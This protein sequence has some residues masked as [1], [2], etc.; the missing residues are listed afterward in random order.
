MRCGL[1]KY[2]SRLALRDIAK[3]KL[4]SDSQRIKRKEDIMAILSFLVTAILFAY[5]ALPKIQI[6]NQGDMFIWGLLFVIVWLI[7]HIFL[8]LFFGPKPPPPTPEQRARAKA[9]FKIWKGGREM[10]EGLA[11]LGELDRDE[12]AHGEAKPQQ[13]GGNWDW[14]FWLVV[15]IAF[16]W[17]L[18]LR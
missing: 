10:M 4:D 9:A 12:A 16:C 2:V 8:D 11:E 17:F 18:F 14:L 3:T 15:I 6:R 13:S 1:H 7:V 5:F